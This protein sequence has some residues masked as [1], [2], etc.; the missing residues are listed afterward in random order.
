MMSYYDKQGKPITVIEW[1][2]LS[3]DPSYKDVAFD[4]KGNFTVTTYWTGTSF[5]MYPK[6]FETRVVVSAAPE[7]FSVGK[8]IIKL[9]GI[10]VARSW[11][12]SEESAIKGHIQACNQHKVDVR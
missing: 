2:E 3:Y 4:V 5:D 6:I 8:T 10:T 7:A 9:S 12:D 1:T 11:Y